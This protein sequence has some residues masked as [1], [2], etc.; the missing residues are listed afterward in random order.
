MVRTVN[1]SQVL[2]ALLRVRNGEDAEH[3]L[4][5]LLQAS[6]DPR[7]RQILSFMERWRKEHGDNLVQ[8]RMV[9]KALRINMDDTSLLMKRLTQ[10]GLLRREQVV[11]DEGRKYGYGLPEAGK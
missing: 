10:A 8:S 1:S 11:T 9:A 3:E 4:E 7:E 2:L 6:L 5:L